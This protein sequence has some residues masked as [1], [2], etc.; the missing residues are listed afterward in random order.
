MHVKCLEE[1]SG[2][3]KC[4]NVG[5]YSYYKCEFQEI[6]SQNCRL[7]QNKT[8]EKEFIDNSITHTYGVI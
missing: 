7:K 8:N 2:W 4:S 5:R 3:S 6:I 1:F